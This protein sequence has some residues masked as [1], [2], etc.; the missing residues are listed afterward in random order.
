MPALYND[1]Y[2]STR[3]NQTQLPELPATKLI[4]CIGVE[5]VVSWDPFF[6]YLKPWGILKNSPA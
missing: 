1:H 6:E 2:R 4:L 3:D 5:A